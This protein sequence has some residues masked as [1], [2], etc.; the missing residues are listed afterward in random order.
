MG[1][2]GEGNEYK[3]ARGKL[4]VGGYPHYIDCDDGFMVIFM[5]QNASNCTH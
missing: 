4:G 1:G 5:C 3:W 2:S